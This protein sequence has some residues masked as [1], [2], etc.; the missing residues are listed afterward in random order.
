MADPQLEVPKRSGSIHP[1][2]FWPRIYGFKCSICGHSVASHKA[3]WHD[4]RRFSV[5]RRPGSADL[6]W[7]K[8]RSCPKTGN[9]LAVCFDHGCSSR[10][11]VNHFLESDPSARM[12]QRRL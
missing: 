12:V 9:R 1:S 3:V 8:C 6:C 7:V 10:I 2:R 5:E 4:E 11:P